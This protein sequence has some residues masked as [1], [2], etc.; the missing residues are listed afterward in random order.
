MFVGICLVDET[1]AE[2]LQDDAPAVQGLV[3]GVRAAY[4]VPQSSSQ[5]DNADTVTDTAVSLDDLMAQ[6]KAM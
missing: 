2:Q 4:S 1:P 6:M 3:E 5:T